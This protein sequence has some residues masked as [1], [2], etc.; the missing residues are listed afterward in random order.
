MYSLCG[1]YFVVLENTSLTT[2]VCPRSAPDEFPH[3][4]LHG[5]PTNCVPDLPRCVPIPSTDTA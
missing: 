1:R 4:M 5:F 3:R 2:K